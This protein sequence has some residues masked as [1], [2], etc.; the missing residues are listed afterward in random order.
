MAKAEKNSLRSDPDERR[1]ARKFYRDYS[2]YLLRDVPLEDRIEV[3]RGVGRAT[4]VDPWE[5]D[6]ERLRE[7]VVFDRDILNDYLK[8]VASRKLL[9]AEEERSLARRALAA[10]EKARRV[11][12]ESNLRLVISIAK[13]Y[14][15]RG[16]PLLDL[17]QEGNRGLLRAIEK[18]DPNRGF[19]FTTYASWW[20]KQAIVRAI[21]NQSRNIRLPV[22]MSETISRI[23]R[24]VRGL[25]AQLGRR[26]T[27]AELSQA[28]QVPWRKIQHALSLC[29]D[30]ISLEYRKYEDEEISNLGEFVESRCMPRP[31]EIIKHKLLREQV[32]GVLRTLNFKEQMVIKYRFGLIN[33]R[34]ST[35]EEIG[36]K[37]G[38]SRERVRQIEASA[39]LQLRH[40]TRSKKL[41]EFYSEG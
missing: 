5:D 38:V 40:P 33:G 36:H 8:E 24:A 7:R 26:P 9:T 4:E 20:I 35:L 10:D 23:N 15:K 16:I 32:E 25:T 13:K 18:Y 41:A 28:L 37:F 14:S 39:L 6:E 11:L 3:S 29:K 19:R 12:I 1:A 21:A 34:E 31:E 30:T 17:I 27:S 2:A 22:H